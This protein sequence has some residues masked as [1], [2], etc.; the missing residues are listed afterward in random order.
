[1]KKI[2]LTGMVITLVLFLGCVDYASDTKVNIKNES[3]Y[4]L[5]LTFIRNVQLA[6]H[7]PE[8]WKPFDIDIEKHSAFSFNIFGGL[9]S[10]IA[11]NPNWEYARIIFYDLYDN[12]TIL[13]KMEIN[14]FDFINQ[15]HIQIN[16]PFQLIETKDHGYYQNAVYFFGIT[17]DLLE[18]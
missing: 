1:M 18:Q 17:D 13:K 9:G 16:N 4:D 8:Y 11:P 6:N 7:D 2:L 10:A 12:E 15:N 14:D 3:S 5:R